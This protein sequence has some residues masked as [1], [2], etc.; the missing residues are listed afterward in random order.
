MVRRLLFELLKQEF[1]VWI[2]EHAYLNR[3]VRC[4]SPELIFLCWFS[5]ASSFL[6]S[7]CR[8]SAILLGSL[9]S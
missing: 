7:S 6:I 5:S 2:S 8:S 4:N 1:M 9:G 3:G